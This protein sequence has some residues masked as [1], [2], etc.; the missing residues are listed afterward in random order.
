[1][2]K[3]FQLILLAVHIS[4][5]L[6]LIRLWHKKVDSYF[7]RGGHFPTKRSVKMYNS[8]TH[9]CDKATLLAYRYQKLILKRSYCREEKAA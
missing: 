3:K 5:C 2:K 6:M 7:K 8:L 9:H 4:F 1:M